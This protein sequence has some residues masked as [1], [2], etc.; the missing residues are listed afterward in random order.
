MYIHESIT[1]I[2]GIIMSVSQ[3]IDDIKEDLVTY[4]MY[5]NLMQ[6]FF[7]SIG[8]HTLCGGDGLV[9]AHTQVAE[10]LQKAGVTGLYQLLHHKVN[11]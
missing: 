6:I 10:E 8:R 4:S 7:Y 11:F 3:I 9:I 5:I 1:D 2:E